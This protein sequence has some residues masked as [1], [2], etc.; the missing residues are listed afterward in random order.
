MPVIFDR[1]VNKRASFQLL[2]TKAYTI[3]STSPY[4]I[5][6][7]EVPDQPSIVTIAGMT[8]VPGMPTA[9]NT[10]FVD[11]LLGDIYFHSSNAGQQVTPAYWGKGSLIRAEDQNKVYDYLERADFVTS[12]MRASAQNTPNRSIKI[13]AGIFYYASERKSY[14]GNANI[15]MGPGGAFQL[16]ALIPNYF[17]KILFTLNSAI[18]LKKYEGTQAG[19]KVDIVAPTLP[20]GEIPICMVTVQDNGTG[21]AGTINNIQ[22]TDIE[23]LRTFF[24]V[25]DIRHRYLTAHLEGFPIL[26]DVFFDGHYFAE[27]VTIDKII[28]IARSSPSNSDLQ[29]E[30]LKN[31]LSTGKIA[32]LSGISLTSLISSNFRSAGMMSPG[33]SSLNLPGLILAGLTISGS[34]GMA[35]PGAP[36]LDM[37]LYGIAFHQSTTLSPSLSFTPS[38][39]LGLKVVAV[40]SGETAEGVEAI[41]NYF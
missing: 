2:N 40:D 16:S 25:P 23:D 33:K 28:L 22:P 9:T 30:M 38:D 13:E 31:G 3:P 26:N 21:T 41:L 19:A 32:T 29:I 6:L 8:E 18:T 37:R 5:S 24:Y 10:F 36:R 4:M 14:A 39:R 1:E 35:F 7:E 17:N 20:A 34:P 27:A 11:Y 15:D 12:M